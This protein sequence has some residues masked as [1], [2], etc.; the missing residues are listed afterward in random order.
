VAVAWAYLVERSAVLRVILRYRW[1]VL[2]VAAV[3]V[4]LLE[5]HTAGPS[6]DGPY[7]EA[8][9][10]RLLSAAGLHVYAAPGLQAGP[11][12]VGAFGLL[13]RA[14]DWMH[15]PTDS[16]YAVISTLAS[17]AL[18]VI[19]VRLLRRQLGFAASATAE[20]LSGVLAIGWLMTTEVYT[21]GHPAELV[22][23]A[24]WIAAAA[25]ST[26]NRAGR[27]GILLGL[28][29]GFETWALL[30]VPV[31]L[32]CA[33]WRAAARG[34]VAAVG[35]T[36]ATY[37]PFVIA[38]PF[39]MGKATWPVSRASFIH[40]IAPRLDSFPWSARLLESV[41]VVGFGVLACWVARRAAAGTSA[42]VWL[43]PTVIALAKAIS[44]P[45][46]YDWYWLPVQLSLL[47]GCSCA[48]GLTRRAAVAVFVAEAVAVTTPLHVWPI[49][50]AAL[51]A[52]L[53]STW[54]GGATR[55][56]GLAPIHGARGAA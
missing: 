43:V 26:D 10:R 31:L 23:P 14:T 9:G 51:A 15:L 18:V 46:G 19:G 4:A 11:W 34:V 52:L 49:A 13:A 17:T 50:L 53:V 47:A 8:A 27:A 25:Q 5:V 16:T 24:L 42:A 1:F 41:V 6:N 20:L 2:L 7:F 40:V 12:Q 35:V 38:G 3:G 28:G 39:R 21:S 30:G 37:L 32:L 55:S 22:I 48:D 33:D 45:S 54:T 29:A 56:R 44:E 36:A